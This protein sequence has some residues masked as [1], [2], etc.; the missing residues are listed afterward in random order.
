MNRKLLILFICTLSLNISA[1]KKVTLDGYLND[2][3]SV[4]H[5]EQSGWLWE[6][7][8]HNRLNLNIYP[9][10]WLKIS[11]QARSRLVQGS[12]YSTFPGYADMV[13]R[14]PGWLDLTFSAD[15]SYNNDLGYI[16]TSKIDRAYAEF[17]FGDWVATV[18]R[19]RINWGQ[20][21]AW[22]PND[23]FNSY[24]YFDVDYPERPGSDAIRVQYYTGIASNI[25]LV[26][27]ADSAGKIT[28][29]GYF[30]FNTM[31][32]DFQLLG[33][34]LSGSDLVLGAGWS[35]N[36]V[37]S[38]FRGEMSYFRDLDNFADTSGHLLISA[39][40]D[41]TFSNSLWL[42]SEIL[43]SGFARDR[44]IYNFMQILGSDMDV[45]QIGFTEWSVFTSLS[46]PIT[47]LINAS[48]AGIWF[49]S[50]KGYYIGPSIDF[51]LSNNISAS[52]ISQ[53]FSAELADPAGQV[54]RQNTWVGYARIKW[55]F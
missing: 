15:G 49:P 35:G 23:I 10:G 31:G 7:Q 11:I 29:A 42:R 52:L 33:G 32:Y 2:M 24:S 21:F 44:E 25:E 54:S 6:N 39:G 19:Q 28:G 12:T 26:A 16:I 38:S 55:S 36:I 34:V 22:N 5:M 18:G 40:I 9:A 43:Y 48:L 4:Y 17:T 14:D 46:Y 3:Q 30:R 41:H 47:P 51:S 1:Q 50:W 53:V 45:K 37:N 27:K 20:T 8:L 13:G